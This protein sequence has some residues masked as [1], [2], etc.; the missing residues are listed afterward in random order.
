[1]N[2][3]DDLTSIPNMAS[4]PNVSPRLRREDIKASRVPVI[5]V[6]T[7]LSGAEYSNHAGTTN[8]LTHVKWHFVPPI[9]SPSLVILD[10]S[11]TTTIPIAKWISSGVRAID[12][13]VETLCHPRCDGESYKCAKSGLEALLPGLLQCRK[14]HHSE[15]L[16]GRLQCQLGAMNSMA[17]V[18]RGLQLGASHG[19]GHMLGPMGVRHGETSCVLMPAV[20]RY[21]A[22]HGLENRARQEAVADIIWSSPDIVSDA[23]RSRGLTRG[24]ADLSDMLDAFI[25]ELGMPRTLQ[26][27]GIERCHLEELAERSLKDDLLRTNPVLITSK[28]QVLEILEKVAG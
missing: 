11:L 2:S 13:C 14:L 3:F 8:D 1:M 4:L 22:A 25:T 6:P 21:N 28:E 19:I 12:H 27:V 24:E 23:L 9:Q 16:E 18:H 15:E 26:E 10:P 5:S 17:F 20:A 7:T